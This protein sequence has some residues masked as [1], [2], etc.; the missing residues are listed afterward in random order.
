MEECNDVS[1]EET[2]V[3][4]VAHDQQRCPPQPILEASQPA[5]WQIDHDLHQVV[6]SSTR[7][8]IQRVALLHSL[9]RIVRHIG[10]LDQ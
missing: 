8:P 2:N 3:R 5:S 4:L 10:Y 6:Q 7:M 9:E 1:G